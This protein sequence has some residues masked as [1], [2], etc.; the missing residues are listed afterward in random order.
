MRV[1]F[2]VD[3]FGGGD[4]GVGRSALRA[5]PSGLVE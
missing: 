2:G 5:A 1:E 4:D 3:A